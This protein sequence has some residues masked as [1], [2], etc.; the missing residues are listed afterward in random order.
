MSKRSSS[1]LTLEEVRHIATLCR[2]G[3]SESELEVMR[4]QL[5]QILE[6][7]AI[8][9]QVETATIPTTDHSIDLHSVTREDI[10]Q[11]SLA[12][13]ATLANAPQRKDNY[14]QVKAVLE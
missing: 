6:Q 2:I 9:Q 8:L 11:P 3:L 1:A 7:F 5:S 10:E 13:D 14:F 12:I 4:N